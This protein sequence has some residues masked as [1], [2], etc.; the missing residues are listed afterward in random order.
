MTN[1]PAHKDD[2]ADRVREC[3]VELNN[4]VKAAAE[5]GIKVEMRHY[6]IVEFG[7]GERPVIAVEL[8]ERR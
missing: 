1:A 8:F 2:I 5:R 3:V 4:A 6:T 7:A